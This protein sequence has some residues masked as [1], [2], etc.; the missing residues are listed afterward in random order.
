MWL[1]DYDVGSGGGSIVNGGHGGCDGSE[2][3]LGMRQWQPVCVQMRKVM[4]VSQHTGFG[5]LFGDTVMRVAWATTTSRQILA[6]SVLLT[7]MCTPR[8]N[9]VALS[10]QHHS[11]PFV[12]LL[13]R[14]CHFHVEMF[15]LTTVAFAF[16]WLEFGVPTP[17]KDIAVRPRHCL[18]S[19]LL[20]SS[21]LGTQMLQI[22]SRLGS[23]S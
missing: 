2:W 22:T 17:T 19:A 10:S 5:L 9:S 21:A 3:P 12:V 1:V 18:R 8:S 15:P 4:H 20:F 7:D 13:G 14:E 23:S 11:P 16:C 6:S